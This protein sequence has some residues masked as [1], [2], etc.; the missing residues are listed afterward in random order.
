MGTYLHITNFFSINEHLET[1]A[2]GTFG[3][4]TSGKHLLQETSVI[5]H[6]KE[7]CQKSSRI[8]LADRLNL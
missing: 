4:R 8:V 6:R 3:K 7:T 1:S 2:S 5:N